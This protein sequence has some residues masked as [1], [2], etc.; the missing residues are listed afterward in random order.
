MGNDR[1]GLVM[2]IEIEGWVRVSHISRKTSE[3]LGTLELLRG[4]SFEV[5]G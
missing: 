2:G 5:V 4:W 3:M 1:P